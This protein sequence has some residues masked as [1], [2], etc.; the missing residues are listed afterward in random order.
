MESY[1]EAVLFTLTE[2]ESRLHRLEYLLGGPHRDTTDKASTVPGRLAA[3]ERT[4]QQLAGKT[5]LLHDARELG[6]C[7]RRCRP[8][9]AHASSPQAPRRAAAP[10][11][12]WPSRRP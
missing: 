5:T 8:C 9:H 7:A 2:L 10:R 3:L 6:G 12:R 11:L 1:D 4:L